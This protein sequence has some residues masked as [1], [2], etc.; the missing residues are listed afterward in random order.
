MVRYEVQ[1]QAE[2]VLAQGI[3]QAGECFLAAKFGIELAVIDDVIAMGAARPGLE[4]GRGVEMRNAELLQI[5]HQR[6][7]VIEGEFLGELQAIGGERNGGRHWA[8][9]PTAA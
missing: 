1:D 5:W 6:R 9:P 3:A 7:S 4:K 8:Q 2:I